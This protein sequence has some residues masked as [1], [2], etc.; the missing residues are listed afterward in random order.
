MTPD[1][2][3]EIIDGAGLEIWV[4]EHLDE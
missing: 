3:V 2:V 4:K 1:L